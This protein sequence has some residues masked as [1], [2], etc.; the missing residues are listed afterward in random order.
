MAERV[1]TADQFKRILPELDDQT[2][3]LREIS[4]IDLMEIEIIRNFLDAL[5]KGENS[6]GWTLHSGD[7]ISVTI[8]PLITNGTQLP[9]ERVS[10]DY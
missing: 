2:S 3:K 6:F 1:F 7:R 4:K 9:D 5:G 8:P 10:E